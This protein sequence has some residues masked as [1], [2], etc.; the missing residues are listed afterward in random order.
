MSNWTYKGTENFEIPSDAFGFVYRI[1]SKLDGRKYIGRKY[2]K[3]SKITSNRVKLKN[4]SKVI[5]KK[6]MWKATGAITLAVVN[7]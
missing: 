3:A 7:L 1:T 6:I 4:G 5:K 2:L